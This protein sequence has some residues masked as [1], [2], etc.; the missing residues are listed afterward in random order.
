MSSS[1]SQF[2]A[3]GVSKGVEIKKINSSL[4]NNK[5]NMTNAKANRTVN[6]SL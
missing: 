4:I 1:K 3:T 5:K 6:N 2:Y